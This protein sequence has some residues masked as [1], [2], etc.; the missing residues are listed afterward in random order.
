MLVFFTIL[1]VVYIQNFQALYDS[2]TACGGQRPAKLVKCHEWNIIH[3]S[4]LL[5]RKMGQQ[6]DIEMI[7]LEVKTPI[8]NRT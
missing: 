1:L 6:M 2:T 7:L 3:L 5:P 4:P 8:I